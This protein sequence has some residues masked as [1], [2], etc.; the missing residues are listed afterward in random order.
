MNNINIKDT[1]TVANTVLLVLCAYK[2][3]LFVD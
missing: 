2:Y 1:M 3:L